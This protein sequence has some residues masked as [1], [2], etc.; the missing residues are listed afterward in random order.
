[1]AESKTSRGDV[2]KEYKHR[3]RGLQTPKVTNFDRK[4]DF[5]NSTRWRDSQCAVPRILTLKRPTGETNGL[6]PT[7]RK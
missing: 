6:G 2:G 3:L 5:S 7:R 4:E 1:V